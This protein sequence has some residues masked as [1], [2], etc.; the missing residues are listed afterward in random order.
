MRVALLIEYDGIEYCGWQRQNNGISVQQTVEE[1]L[2]ILTKTEITLFGAGRTDAGV[3]A[4][5]QV[6]HF[7]TNSSVPPERYAIAMNS[8]LP[9]DIRIRK[10]WQEKESFHARFSARGKHYKYVICNAAHNIAIGSRYCMHYPLPLDIEKMRSAAQHIIGEHDF[11]AFSSAG[12]QT[13]TT[14][15][16]IDS[17]EISKKGDFIE[18]D[19]KGNGFLY[20]MVRIIAGTLIYVGEGKIAASEIPQI[21][22]SKNRKRAGI[23]ARPEGLFLW[24]VYY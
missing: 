20:N 4:K 3:H 8:L 19:V 11:E 13:K 18:I 14:V 17:I 9:K 6:A 2:K 10:S 24:E 12:R 7:D 23:T 22:K 15:R 5:G 1:V 16:I 21:I